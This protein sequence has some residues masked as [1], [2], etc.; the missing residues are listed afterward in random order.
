MPCKA[1]TPRGLIKLYVD[2]SD[3]PG[4]FLFELGGVHASSWQLRRI[5]NLTKG[6]AKVAP[7]PP[8]DVVL[9]KHRRGMTGH[10]KP[11]YT[12]FGILFLADATVAANVSA[13]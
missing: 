2:R 8:A 3:K 5:V 4:H 13:A 7:P 6:C 11:V 10:P 9:S 12:D 1:P